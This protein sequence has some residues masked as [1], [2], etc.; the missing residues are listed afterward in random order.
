MEKY[1]QELKWSAIKEC[2]HIL[3]PFRIR[4]KLGY[5]FSYSIA[6]KISIWYDRKIFQ[7]IPLML[8]Y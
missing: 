6:K 3:N 8:K 1:L 5:F 2:R 7:K 4:A